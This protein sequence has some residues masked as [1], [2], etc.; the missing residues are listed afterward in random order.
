MRLGV[1][2]SDFLWY[3]T[4]MITKTQIKSGIEAI[5]DLSSPVFV[6]DVKDGLAWVMDQDG[7]EQWVSVN[8]LDEVAPL[9]VPSQKQLDQEAW[10]AMEREERMSDFWSFFR[11][12]LDSLTLFLIVLIMDNTTTYHVSGLFETGTETSTFPR[13]REG[14]D[15]AYAF[16]HNAAAYVI[17]CGAEVVEEFDPWADEARREMASASRR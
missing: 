13:T 9:P 16:A 5:L 8:R 15:G 14:L 11:K 12:K 6:G 4:H 2:F 3:N 7:G 1:D 10:D 17:R